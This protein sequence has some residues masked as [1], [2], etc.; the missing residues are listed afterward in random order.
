MPA[1]LP[2]YIETRFP[3]PRT[4]LF[5]RSAFDSDPDLPSFEGGTIF[6][7]CDYLSRSRRAEPSAVRS[8][9]GYTGMPLFTISPADIQIRNPLYG[10]SIFRRRA[11]ATHT[12]ALYKA[13]KR[14]STRF[15]DPI[16]FGDPKELADQVVNVTPLHFLAR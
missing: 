13:S 3:D 12:R 8:E 11:V 4:P 5:Y 7:S 16:V 14:N 6:G 10:R 2:R 1:D 15:S 9:S